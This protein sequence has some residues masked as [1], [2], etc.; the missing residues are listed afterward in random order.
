MHILDDHDYVNNGFLTI[1]NERDVLSAL[2]SVDM[3]V[4]QT[5]TTRPKRRN[6]V[7]FAEDVSIVDVESDVEMVYFVN[8]VLAETNGSSTNDANASLIRIA[9]RNDS[10]VIC[11]SSLC[12]DA[13]GNVCENNVQIIIPSMNKLYAMNVATATNDQT[14]PAHPCMPTLIFQRSSTP[15]APMVND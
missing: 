8:E 11:C 15:T 1:N 2:S 13:D 6:R 14:I 9:D 10:I 5:E 3:F 12:F 7:R 4:G